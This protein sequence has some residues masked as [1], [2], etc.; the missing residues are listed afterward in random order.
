MSKEI[1][2]FFLESLMD[3]GF[4]KDRAM[5][6]LS[7]TGQKSIDD[8]LEYLERD[9]DLYTP[10]PT[11]QSPVVEKSTDKGKS[12]ALRVSHQSNNDSD[13]GDGEEDYSMEDAD[14]EDYLDEEAVGAFEE[15]TPKIE[16]ATVLDQKAIEASAAKE[17]ERIASITETSLST[18]G[19]LLRAFQWNSEKLLEQYCDN[20]D[21]V[22]KTAGITMESKVS[23]TVKPS[24]TADECCICSDDLDDG[25][26]CIL[27]C[28]HTFC[29]GCLTQY[30]TIHINE[31]KSLDITCMAHKCKGRIPDKLIKRLV[32][33]KVY[34]KYMAFVSK[35]FVEDN[36]NIQWCPR[37]K[38]G[39]AVK[40]DSKNISEAMCSCGYKFCFKCNK[41]AHAPATCSMMREWAKKCKDDSETS[42][43]ISANTKD[44]PKCHS[45]IEKNGGCNHMTCRKCKHEFCWICFG[46]WKGHSAWNKS[47]TFPSTPLCSTPPT[48]VASPVILKKQLKYKNLHKLMLQ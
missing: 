18:A 8:A 13:D 22:L 45:S 2:S 12:K 21:K 37:P 43:W 41:E 14:S 46:D 31:G 36:P 35:S 11:K 20:P 42:N 48:A 27:D 32:D 10:P 17:I 9:V 7:V 1:N 33:D 38:C 6:A 47:I 15:S 39:N 24:R 28:N 5:H 19:A 44:C 16:L 30:L 25:N 34:T 3:M 23:T 4:S 40:S 26:A 29:D